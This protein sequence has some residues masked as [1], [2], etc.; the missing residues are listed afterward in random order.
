LSMDGLDAFAETARGGERAAAKAARAVGRSSWLRAATGL[1]ILGPDLVDVVGLRVL[2][3][4]QESPDEI[5]LGLDG[6]EP[7][8]DGGL[9]GRA[10]VALGNLWRVGTGPQSASRVYAQ[11]HWR[12]ISARCRRLSP[13]QP[14]RRGLST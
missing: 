1:T 5:G 3:T 4:V 13:L 12:E 6:P 7:V 8:L 14:A 9:G 11:P 10:A 2:P